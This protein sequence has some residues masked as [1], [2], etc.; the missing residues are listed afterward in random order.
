VLSLR[1][2]QVQPHA[3][4][5]VWTDGHLTL[6]LPGV[7]ST[8]SSAE[9]PGW[10]FCGG[11]ASTPLPAI[12]MLCSTPH[13]NLRL[14]SAG[15]KTES[16]PELPPRRN[17]RRHAAFRDPGGRPSERPSRKP[18]DPREFAEVGKLP[19]LGSNQQPAG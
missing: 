11:A 18:T 13:V 10:R 15:F 9:S 6:Y 14:C 3:E 19:E 2:G 4:R 12:L 7:R 16:A 5:C 1:H 17:P 8:F